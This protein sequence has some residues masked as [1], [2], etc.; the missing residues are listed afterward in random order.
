MGRSA[1]TDRRAAVLQTSN[2]GSA[3]SVT[4]GYFGGGTPGPLSTV[5]R[6]DYANDTAT[7]SPKGPLTSAKATTAGMSS[8]DGGLP[9]TEIGTKANPSGPVVALALLIQ[10]SRRT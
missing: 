2:A 7:A 8:K 9:K 4:H 5:Q 1:S 6:I 3:S 10:S